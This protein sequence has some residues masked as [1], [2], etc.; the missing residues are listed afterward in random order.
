MNDIWFESLF[1]GPFNIFSN[2][3]VRSN[4]ILNISSR[5]KIYVFTIFTHVET[6][7]KL[8]YTSVVSFLIFEDKNYSCI[9]F[10]RHN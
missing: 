8:A 5:K 10:K 7:I 1:N 9:G 6:H 4:C 3:Y 2:I